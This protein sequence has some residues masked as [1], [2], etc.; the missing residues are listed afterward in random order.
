M[1]LLKD[2]CMQPFRNSCLS[3]WDG[4]LGLQ[5]TGLDRRALV[6]L[7]SS[8]QLESPLLSVIKLELWACKPKLWH[9]LAF[10]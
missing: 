6:P 7:Q 3:E 2:C 4:K 8:Q 10:C 5:S 1:L 9:S